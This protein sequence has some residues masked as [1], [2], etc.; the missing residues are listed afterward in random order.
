MTSPLPTRAAEF[1]VELRLVR[2]ALQEL[3]GRR[4]ANFLVVRITTVVLAAAELLFLSTVIQLALALP[5]AWYF[6]RA[7]TMALPAN[8]LVIP[9]AGVLLPSAVLA[10]ALS[11]LSHWLALIPAVIAAIRAR[12][13]HRHDP[14]HRPSANFRRACAHPDAG[15]LVG[16][17]TCI[18]PGSAARQTASLGGNRNRWTSGFRRLD[19]ALAAEAAMASWRVR[20]DGHRRRP[21]RFAAA[22]H[23]RG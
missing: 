19:C 15:C 3:V 20:G 4:L 6:H 17:G 10:V 12:R 18:R 13:S 11:Y 23:A 22:D 9:I 5:M 16:C 7:T 1:R 21:G 2:G 8:A 14:H